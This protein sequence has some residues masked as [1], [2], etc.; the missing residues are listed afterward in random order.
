MSHPFHLF[1]VSEIGKKRK[2]DM[3]DGELRRYVDNNNNN[4]N[5]NNMYKITSFMVQNS[6]RMKVSVVS[7]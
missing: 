4:N 1:W 6:A 2:S 7:S 5:N 3:L